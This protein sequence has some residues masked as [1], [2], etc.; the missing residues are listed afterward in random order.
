MNNFKYWILSSDL[1][2]SKIREINFWSVEKDRRIRLRMTAIWLWVTD[3]RV[4]ELRASD[5]K[6]LG[7]WL[8]VITRE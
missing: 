8:Q 4:T 1:D 6:W 2:I 7:V 5:Y 3:W